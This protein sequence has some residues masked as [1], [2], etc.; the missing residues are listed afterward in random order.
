LDNGLTII[1]H[2]DPKTP[3]VA[4]NVTYH[5][6]S[7]HEPRSKAG[8]AHIAEHLMFAGTTHQ[9]ENFFLPFERLGATSMNAVSRE[10]YTAY[11][12]AVPVE[13]FDAA[14]SMEAER[15]EFLLPA[16]D[17]SKLD[18]QCDIVRNELLQREHQPYGIA[19]RLISQHAYPSEHPY[20]HPADGLVEDLG[21]ITIRDVKGWFEQHYGAA[22]AT[23]VI[24]GD[25]DPDYALDTAQRHFRSIH[26]GPGVLRV[27][28][29]P[30]KPGMDSRYVAQ[31]EY[32]TAS[33]LYLVWNTPPFGSQNSAALELA[34][35]VL[36]G[37]AASRLYHRLVREKQIASGVLIEN[38]AGELGS[39]IVLS[40]IAQAETDLSVVEHE[41]RGEVVRFGETGPSQREL[42]TARLRLFS[43]FIR[44]TE[45]V[46]GQLS[47]SDILAL[48]A[49][50]AGDPGA[51]EAHLARIASI[52]PGAIRDTCRE[53]LHDGSF[54][55]EVRAKRPARTSHGRESPRHAPPTAAQRAAHR[56][57][58]VEVSGDEISIV[59]VER[60]GSP[61]FEFRL[62]VDG[63]FASDPINQRGLASTVVSALTDGAERVGN[64]TIATHE[65]K[66]S[67]KITGRARIDAF[68]IGLSAVE[69][70]LQQSLKL[71]ADIV[72][73]PAFETD[74][75][76]RA[77]RSRLA[78]IDQEK[79]KPFDL[80]MRIL[81]LLA[82][83]AG[84]PYAIPM[85]GS[86][87]ASDVSRLSVD[88]VRESHSRWFKSASTTLVA[89]G[90]VSVTGL[91]DI[92]SRA[93]GRRLP[94][95]P[96]SHTPLAPAPRPDPG[97]RVILVDQPGSVQSAIF[98]AITTEPRNSRH[99]H[100]LMV[101][102]VILGGVFGSRLNMALRE[103]KGWTYGT[104]STLLHARGPGLWLI[105][106][107]VA[108]NVTAATMLE[109]EIQMKALGGTC[110]LTDEE[111][112]RATDYL[113]LRRPA[114]LETNG[115]IAAAFED[116]SLFRLPRT[117]SRDFTTLIRK[118]Q[119]TDITDVCASIFCNRPLVWLVV[120]DA[121]T[122][123]AQIE[124]AGFGTPEVMV[125]PDD[126]P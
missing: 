99:V 112:A 113:L 11:F 24:A 33:R 76:E 91:T 114:E 14:L 110:P 75:I 85:T 106:T 125:G 37:G 82:Y 124:S 111:F 98:A 72:T 9:S 103:E 108:S 118:I 23:L 12:E 83:G 60:Y 1:T 2:H 15:M 34:S 31:D 6:G 77:K 121:W 80:A 13:S 115:Q 122:L 51:Y 100:A 44:R 45:R 95:G 89:V 109:I 22:N 20:W 92:A 58:I 79:T 126:I 53:W 97:Q 71:L 10:D 56:S 81:P 5:A 35:E 61:L 7:R 21:N 26:S 102:D 55:L 16:L 101:A 69:Q 105:S 64:E 66:L 27:T 17:Q 67:A 40:V 62:I 43:Q 70:K 63:G 42:I 78:L 18:R 94:G 19:P 104:R 88:N 52:G 123:R 25:V 32:A 96:A 28:Q 46:C 39:Q 36:A 90:P 47:K 50:I 74:V 4:I 73:H 86:G 65:D 57:P 93:F 30:S 84:H 119:I 54:I 87:T 41:L 117:Y 3:I 68:V 8:L 116:A 38:R 49:L 29:P 107:F 120:G 59:A 48:G